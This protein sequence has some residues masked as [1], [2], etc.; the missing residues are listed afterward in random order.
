MRSAKKGK[1]IP[2]FAL[3]K[4]DETLKWVIDSN[5]LIRT[6]EKFE[7]TVNSI[8]IRNHAWGGT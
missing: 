2:I 8:L 5:I 1:T 7:F 6:A 3:P 4:L